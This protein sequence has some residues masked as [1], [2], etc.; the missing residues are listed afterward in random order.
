MAVRAG[1][2]GGESLVYGLLVAAVGVAT[3]V[4][5]VG[6][7]LAYNSVW[8]LVL[9]LVS[10]VGEHVLLASLMVA[11]WGSILSVRLVATT[12]VT[13]S[14]THAVLDFYH[15][16]SGLVDKRD[17]VAK[18][19]ASVFTLGFGGSLGP[20][21]P[22]LLIGSS[23]G[24]LVARAAGMTIERVKRLFLAGAAAGMTA[25]FRT[26]LTGF[27]FALEIPYKR[28]L[29]KE[30]FLEAAVASVISY[31]I[32]VSVVGPERLFRSQVSVPLSPGVL[33][34]SIVFGVLAGAYS[35][36]F[37]RLNE[38][39]GR[40]AAEARKRGWFWALGLAGGLSV[41]LIGL[42]S[43]DAIGVGVETVEKL[44]SGGLSSPWALVSLLLLKLAATV[45]TV[46]FGGSG[47]MFFPALVDGALLGAAFS[48]ALGLEPVSLYIALGMVAMLS[49]THKILLAPIAFVAE[50][51]GPSPVIPALLASTVSYFVS[52][53]RSFF[54]LQPVSKLREEELALER[55]Y[56]EALAS[57]PEALTR[58]SVG[59]VMSKEP[60]CLSSG[61]SVQ[62]ALERFERVPY[63]VLPVVEEEGGRLVGYVRL[64]DLTLV[65]EDRSREPVSIATVRTPLA[66]SPDTP[67]AEV[68]ERM[69]ETNEDHAFVVDE[70]GRLL[71]VVADIDLVRHLLHYVH[72][73]G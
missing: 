11:F 17:S 9:G 41:G 27:L 45:A 70:E 44:L 66:F 69:L 26:P 25:V 60:Y 56:H 64:E 28:D 54:K 49:G 31:L 5:V 2:L 52:G 10:S 12:K 1:G 13:G 50:T 61:M 22:A 65:A 15:L 51:V 6:F 43:V 20:E 24:S 48:Y 23:V 3:S 36:F 46:N 37:V 29:E 34:Y 67:V 59:E 19:L 38:L 71:G 55:L 14:G 42:A 68:V 63:R 18:T 35:Y 7:F 40:V 33:A 72:H 32:A 58:H 62:E 57:S 16:R 47:G 21:G 30:H 53:G 4:L 73:G 8:G 39:A